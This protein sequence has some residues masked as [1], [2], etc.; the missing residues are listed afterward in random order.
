MEARRRMFGA[1]PC[2]RAGLVV[3]WSRVGLP[4]RQDKEEASPAVA[5]RLS[6]GD[7]SGLPKEVHSVAH[8]QFR[9]G[10][11]RDIEGYRK[12]RLQ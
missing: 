4:K 2:K 1:R 10:S 11:K 9:R 7:G 3:G 6:S 12:R 8:D 5:V